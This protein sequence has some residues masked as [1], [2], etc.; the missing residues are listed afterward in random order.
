MLD[1]VGAL[2][3]PSPLK[4]VVV[5]PGLTA[6]AV[7]SASHLALPY[8]WVMCTVPLLDTDVDVPSAVEVVSLTASGDLRFLRLLLAVTVTDTVTGTVTVTGTGT[9]NEAATGTVTGTVTGIDT[10]TETGTVTVPGAV[11]F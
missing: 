7:L 5:V 1:I 8:N 11:T 9:G 2:Q 10:G 3:V 6:V 4:K